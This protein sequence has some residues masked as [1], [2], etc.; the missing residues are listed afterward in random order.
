MAENSLGAQDQA[1]INEAKEAYQAYLAHTQAAQAPQSTTPISDAV[2]TGLSVVGHGL[3]TAGG[4]VRTTLA[5][6][7]QHKLK[8][9]AG[10]AQVA[11]APVDPD[12]I[13]FAKPEDI[14]NTLR[15][16]APRTKEY[17]ERVG[18]PNAN[19][20]DIVPGYAEAGKG[21]MF[22]PE[23]GGKLDPSA[24][25]AAGL[26]GDIATDPL[27]YLS[28]GLSNAAKTGTTSDL[29]KKSLLAN[30]QGLTMGGKIA[31]M[32]LN[33]IESLSRGG[34]KSAYA[35]AFEK[36]D[37]KFNKPEQ[38]AKIAQET[39][40]WGSPESSVEH[41]KNIN[42]KAGDKIGTLMDSA[43][44]NGAEVNLDK[45]FQ[46]AL[47]KA[48]ELKGTGN[49]EDAALA[50]QIEKR[51]KELQDAHAK[52]ETS[53]VPEVPAQYQTPMYGK[54]ELVP[55]TGIPQQVIKNRIGSTVPVNEANQIKSN[56]NSF[57]NF[58]PSDIDAVANQSRKAVAQPLSSS[59]KDAIKVSDPDLYERLLEANDRYS[60]TSPQ[61]MKKLEQFSTQAPQQ[62]GPFGGT[63][64]DAILGGAGLAGATHTGGASM[65]PLVAKKL[66]D[67]G[68]SFEGRTARGALLNKIGQ[69]SNGVTDEALRQFILN[70]QGKGNQ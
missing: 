33:P 59:I 9:M 31:N 47:A 57:T 21:G 7:L 38:L 29:L 18:L 30:D 23:K 20:S 27:T 68:Q 48:N 25:G 15:S 6:L 52:F 44:S 14:A 64:V 22:T 34:A 19:L 3:D 63:K 51:V 37:S 16:E 45:S 54:E 65:L 13:N 26:V 56:L 58:N 55:G 66:M 60:S 12:K 39:G 46:S 62:R 35:K 32:V 28:A 11:G 40:F 49:L 70:Q 36:V 4:A 24:L 53:I 67:A 42:Q 41:F 61:V 5:Q 2:K 17:L 10:I 1:D 8:G 50:S 43:A 69:N